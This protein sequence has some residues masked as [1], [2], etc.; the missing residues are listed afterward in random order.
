MIRLYLDAVA[1]LIAAHPDSRSV[2]SR[3]GVIPVHSRRAG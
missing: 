3:E 1:G 2:G